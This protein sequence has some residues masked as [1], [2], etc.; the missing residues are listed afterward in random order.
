M[1]TLPTY[2]KCSHL[3]CQAQR[4]LRRSFCAEH[5]NQKP[6]TSDDRLEASRFYGSTFWRQFKRIQLSKFPLCACCLLAGRITQASVVDHVFPWRKVGTHAFKVNLFQSLC[7][8]CHSRKTGLEQRGIVEHYTNQ[9]V[10]MTL[11]D[12]GYA[13]SGIS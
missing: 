3:G 13:V 8:E 5:L 12:Y 6:A 10:T 7:P 9:L 4:E 1:P 2:T 11:A